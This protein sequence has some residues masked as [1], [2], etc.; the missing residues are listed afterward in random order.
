MPNILYTDRDIIV[1]VKKAGLLS[2][3]GNEENSFPARLSA[4]LREQGQNDA[5]FTVHRLDRDVGGVMVYARTKY[6]AARLSAQIACHGFEK[7]YLTLVHGRPEK[8]SDT[9]TDLLFRDKAKN[10]T[11]IVTR[12]RHGV[13]EAS[14]EYKSLAGYD[15][16]TLIFVK[17]ITGRTHQIRV[18]F[19]SRHNPV[20]GD[21]RYGAPDG[22]GEIHLWSYRV[23]F[24]HP[25]SDK[26]VVFCSLPDWNI[27]LNDAIRAELDKPYD[28]IIPMQDKSDRT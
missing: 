18:Q 19:A 5:V 6:A 11:Y 1:A 4:Y 26:R 28:A 16:N 20:L 10:K 2:E 23:S 27:P 12:M 25:V 14:L 8:N 15:D 7:E 3:N 17:L 21:R 13:K 22:T 9:L 24:I